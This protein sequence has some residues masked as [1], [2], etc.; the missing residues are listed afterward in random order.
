MGGIIYS[1]RVVER[2]EKTLRAVLIGIITGFLVLG[3]ITVGYAAEYPV[4]WTSEVKIKDL[5]EIDALLNKPGF[6]G[7][8]EDYPLTMELGG[9]QIAAGKVSCNEYFYLKYQGYEPSCNA[10][11]EVEGSSFKVP[12]NALQYLKK[13]QPSKISFLQDF[14][15]S[16]D[17]LKNLPLTLGL[18]LSSDEAKEVSTAR[19]KRLT[20]KEFA[21]A[22]KVEVEDPNNI[23][24]DIQDSDG[25][26]SGNLHQPFGMGRFQRGRCGGYFIERYTH[27]RR[28]LS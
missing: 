28:V 13:A 17:P 12:C 22:A 1:C 6:A 25:E 20:W 9:D 14:K 16:D 4:R 19:E 26:V 18:Y 21:P 15:L 5:K 24:I 8:G 23:S 2:R 7:L 3:V 10:A 11:Q 27:H